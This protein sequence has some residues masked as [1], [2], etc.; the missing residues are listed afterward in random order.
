MK[1]LNNQLVQLQILKKM[2]KN[3]LKVNMKKFL[4]KKYIF[5]I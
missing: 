2:I 3:N 1:S 5:Y 4:Y